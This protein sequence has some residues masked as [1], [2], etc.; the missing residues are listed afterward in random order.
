[1]A[2]QQ[3]LPGTGDASIPEI[4]DA[5]R[6]YVKFRDKRMKLLTDEVEARET[7]LRIMKDKRRKRYD[8]DGLEVQV[9]EGKEKVKVSAG[10]ESTETVE[11]EE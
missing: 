11:V 2:N 7:L 10:G 8:Y 6:I 1:M 9:V 3:R 5:A 4:E